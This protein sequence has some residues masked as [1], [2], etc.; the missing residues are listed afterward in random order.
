MVFECHLIITLYVTKQRLTL[1]HET[2]NRVC[3]QKGVAWSEGRCVDYIGINPTRKEYL[4]NHLYLIY[5]ILTGTC[6]HIIKFY[7]YHFRFRLFL[8]ISISSMILLVF[9]NDIEHRFVIFIA[10]TISLQALPFFLVV[11]IP[12]ELRKMHSSI[13]CIYNECKM[14]YIENDIKNWN[15]R[16]SC[17]ETNFVF[18]YF[19]VDLTVLSF[20][21]NLVWLC[22]LA[23]VR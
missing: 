13:D 23:M 17:T 22:V 19:E 12:V 20:V 3:Y 2:P 11:S 15:L 14:K 10:N 6:P 5:L 4:F 18:G 16:Y 1:L 21:F 9:I 8:I 7:Y